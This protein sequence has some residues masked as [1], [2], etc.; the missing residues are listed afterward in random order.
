MSGGGG[1][2]GHRFDKQ[3][4]LSNRERSIE[5]RPNIAAKIIIY[6]PLNN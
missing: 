4:I 2:V 1:G 5:Y 6:R 3:V